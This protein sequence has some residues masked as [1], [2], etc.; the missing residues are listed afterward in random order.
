MSFVTRIAPSPTG[1]FHLGTARTAWF[2]WLAARASGGRFLLRIDDTDLARNDPA[3]VQ[4]I[5]DS[6]AWLGLA[7]DAVFSQSGRL[8][9]YTQVAQDLIAR[10]RAVVADLAKRVCEIHHRMEKLAKQSFT[11][12]IAEEAAGLSKEFYA[13]MGPLIA[14]PAIIA[15]A[16]LKMRDAARAQKAGLP[17]EDDLPTQD[18]P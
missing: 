1:D 9:R 18:G 13:R 8:D 2:N 6:L 11:P 15:R 4:V 16:K 12:D 17:Q 10:G 7:P 14:S 5:H 3:S